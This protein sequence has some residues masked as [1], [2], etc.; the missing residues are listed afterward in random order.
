MNFK[1]DLLPKIIGWTLTGLATLLILPVTLVMSLCAVTMI[2]M[3][4]LF[5]ISAVPVGIL[6]LILKS[7]KILG[8]GPYSPFIIKIRD[9]MYIT[10][11]LKPDDDISIKVTIP[12]KDK[13]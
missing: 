6:A 1:E 8:P 9:N 2:I 11:D 12:G 13:E 10:E 5:G 3:L 4:M 7:T